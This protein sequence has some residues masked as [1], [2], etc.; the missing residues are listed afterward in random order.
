MR[1]DKCAG[2]EL[3]KKIHRFSVKNLA[4][5]VYINDCFRILYSPVVSTNAGLN[6]SV[7]KELSG[8][9]F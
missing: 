7:G 5:T 4:I 8:Q 6:I 2:L 9:N 3:H 1:S